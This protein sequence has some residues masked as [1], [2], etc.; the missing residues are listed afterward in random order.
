MKLLVLLI[1]CFVSL[2]I[3]AITD[4]QP[5]LCKEDKATGIVYYYDKENNAWYCYETWLALQELIKESKKKKE[6]K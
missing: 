6:A 5:T 3:M 4:E 2:P 1:C